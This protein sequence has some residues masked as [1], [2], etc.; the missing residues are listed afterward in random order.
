MI[1]A[2]GVTFVFRIEGT[3]AKGQCFENKDCKGARHL[4]YIDLFQF[5]HFV[6]LVRVGSPISCSVEFCACR[7]TPIDPF[8]ILTSLQ[9]RKETIHAA[10]E[11]FAIRRD[12]LVNITQSLAELL[13]WVESGRTDRDESFE[14]IFRILLTILL[15]QQQ[16]KVLVDLLSHRL[17]Q[18]HG[19]CSTLRTGWKQFVGD[20]VLQHV[21]R[22]LLVLSCVQFEHGRIP[23]GQIRPKKEVVKLFDSGINANVIVDGNHDVMVLL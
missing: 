15:R 21:F 11:S 13:S 8:D 18:L 10:F 12:R 16:K 3:S 4:I 6:T 20:Q 19:L 7:D 17:E 22:A 14:Y 1:G 9:F 23:F 2:S 5:H